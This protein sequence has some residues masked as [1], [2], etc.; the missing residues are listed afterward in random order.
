MTVISGSY[1]KS[2]FSLIEAVRLSFEV[3]APSAFP[4]AAPPPC[5]KLLLSLFWIVAI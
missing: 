5:Q 4:P 3:A 2:T 1:G